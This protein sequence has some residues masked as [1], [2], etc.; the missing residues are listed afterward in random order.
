M[1]EKTA[2][3]D[4]MR[5]KGMRITQQKKAILGVLTDNPDRMLSV[6]DIADMLDGFADNAT[7]YRNMGKF[8]ELGIVETI[9]DSRGVQRYVICC[10]GKHHHHLICTSC[11]RIIYFPCDTPFWRMLAEQNGFAEQY[12]RIEVYGTCRRCQKTL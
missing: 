1:D 10:D 2:I 8:L 6:C 5:R 4:A 9:T 11:G 3:I 7:V 12:H